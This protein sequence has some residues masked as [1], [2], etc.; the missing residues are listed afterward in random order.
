MRILK[1]KRVS[2]KEPKIIAC[3]SQKGG[4]GKSTLARCLAVELTKQKKNILLVDLDIQQKT[5]QE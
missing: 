2:I 4:G 3:L 1:E 5:S